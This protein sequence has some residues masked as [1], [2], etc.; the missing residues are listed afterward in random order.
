M[1]RIVIDASSDYQ[2]EETRKN[3]IEMVPIVVTI[4]EKDY[5]DGVNLDR[6]DLYKIVEETG[7]FPK[8][9]QPSP[10]TFLDIFRDA[11]EKG[12][13]VVCI[14]LSSALSGT[15]QSAVLAKNMSDY[16][17]IY[18]VDSLSAT[19]AIKV[20]AD[21]ACRLREQ[22]Y[23]ASAIAEELEKLKPRVRVLAAMNTLEYL[24]RGGRISKTA[25]AM[26][27]RVNL[28]PIIT[29]TEDG[30][31]G[32]MGKCLGRNKAVSYIMK[33]LQETKP[34]ENFPIYSIYSYG[35]ENSDRFEER[36]SSEQIN[37]SER[38]QIGPTIG[39][40]IGPGAFGIVFVAQN[41]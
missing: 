30:K 2:P 38:L 16:P 9:A 12:D 33:Q 31:V 32:I 25:A 21:Y 20:M 17:E 40:H 7:A 15:Y 14:L 22:N 8:T 39:T 13:S 6:N 4:G 11:K 5:L 26:G 28:K 18:L 1:I 35:T 36:L 41:T 34:D 24:G 37:V 19:Y 3:Q 23:P 10:Q 27:D 29:L